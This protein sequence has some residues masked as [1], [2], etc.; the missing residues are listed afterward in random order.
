ML[1]QYSTRNAMQLA[2]DWR[3]YHRYALSHLPDLLRDAT[4]PGIQAVVLMAYSLRGFPLPGAAWMISSWA[5][6]RA[7]EMGL[8]RSVSAWSSTEANMDAHEIEM[9][10]RIFWSLLVCHVTIGCKLGRP[11]AIRLEDFDVELPGPVLDNLPH[12]VDESNWRKCSFRIGIYSFKWLAIYMQLYST[13]YTVRP[14]SQQ[15]Y[16]VALKNLERDLDSWVKTF[17]DELHASNSLPIQDLV[18][19]LY[20]DLGHQH[21]R[22]LLHHPALCNTP[23]RALTTTNLDVCLDASSRLLDIA[24][25]IRDLKSLD[26]TWFNTTTFIAAIF[27]TLFAHTERQN[28]ITSAELT[29]LREEMDRWLDIMGD[30]GQLLGA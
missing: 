17:P 23:N 13:I 15:P 5:L 6:A 30:I 24:G 14:F 21:L 9:R 1:Y 8:H 3:A 26:T 20:L 11:L 12:E 19:A 2:N 29:T 18:C 10:K 25:Q 22:L 27:T 4:L 7:I 28:D 16:E